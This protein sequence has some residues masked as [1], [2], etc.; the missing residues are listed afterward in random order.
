MIEL[1]AALVLGLLVSGVTYRLVLTSQRA[2]QAQAEQVSLQDNVRAGLLLLGN[3]LR[4][5]GFGEIT[6]DAAAALG[7]PGAA[8][9][10]PDLIAIGP[11]SITYRAVRAVGFTCSLDGAT[12]DVVL[13]SGATYH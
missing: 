9:P 2:A 11:D 4:E 3:E 13:R 8:L 5:V 7:L 1:L 12:G 6:A 10:D